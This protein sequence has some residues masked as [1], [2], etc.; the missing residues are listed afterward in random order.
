MVCFI[1]IENTG[2][3]TCASCG[4]FWQGK[5]VCQIARILSSPSLLQQSTLGRKL[6]TILDVPFISLDELYWQPFWVETPREEFI[7]KIQAFVHQNAERGWVIDGDYEQKGAAEIQQFT[8]DVICE[9]NF[10]P[11]QYIG[12]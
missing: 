1:D 9:S 5:I 12:I 4:R 3:V 8:T 11:Q 10:Q 7:A 6:A 2:S